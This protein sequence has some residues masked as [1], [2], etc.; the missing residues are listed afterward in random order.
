VSVERSI[1]GSWND[2]P[3]HY[4]PHHATPERI[5]KI[6]LQEFK[7]RLNLLLMEA[8]ELDPADLVAALEFEIRELRAEITRTKV[9]RAKPDDA[10]T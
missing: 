8:I 1:S 5:E 7:D 4:S 6:A 3:Y 10:G 2:D 9:V